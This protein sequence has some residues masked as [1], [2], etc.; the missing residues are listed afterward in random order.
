MKKNMIM[1]K[2]IFA[3]LLLVSFICRG[4]QQNLSLPELMTPSPKATMMNRFGYYPT[5]LYTGLVDITIPIYSIQVKD[6]TLP[7]EFKYL[8]S[9][10]TTKTGR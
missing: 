10:L 2:N 4:Q 5:N 9:T 8:L 6:Y 1:K 7:I 3:I